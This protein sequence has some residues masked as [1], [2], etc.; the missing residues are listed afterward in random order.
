VQRSASV[1]VVAVGKLDGVTGHV[2][3]A[4]DVRALALRLLVPKVFA[5][6]GRQ[7]GRS[8]GAIPKNKT[9]VIEKT[10]E[11]LDQMRR[12]PS[13]RTTCTTTYSDWSSP[14]AK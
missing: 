8:F 7:L 10:R 4:T 14:S 11:G 12:Q 3:F 2:Y 13:S 9:R 6:D 1:L 5:S